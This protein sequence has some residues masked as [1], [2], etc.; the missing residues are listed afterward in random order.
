[1]SGSVLQVR[2]PRPSG[3]AGARAAIATS[4]RPARVEELGP[5]PAGSGRSAAFA[6]T[7]ALTI[8]LAFAGVALLISVVMLAVDPK[9]I[10]G[11]DTSQ[12]QDAETAVYLAAFVVILPLALIAGP[13]LSAAIAAGPNASALSSLTALL[14]ST[15]AAAIGLVRLSDLEWGAGMGALLGAAG[16]WWVAAAALLARA[17]QAR[18]WRPLLR[19]AGLAPKLWVV[20]GVL[21]L[22]TLLTVTHLD[23]LSPLPLVLGAAIIPAVVVLVERRSLPR[24]AHRWGVMAEGLIVAALVLATL[25]LVIASP[26]DPGSLL[27]AFRISVIKQ[28]HDFL[29]GPANQVL[30]GSAMLVDTA[31]QYGVGSILFLAGWFK[32]APIGYGTLGFLD[33]LLTALFFVAGYCLL[34]LVGASRLLAASGLAVAV[35]A[36]VINRSYPVGALPQEGPLRFGLPMAL[37]LATVVAARWPSRSRAAQA[38]AL[39]V[40]ALSSIWSAE[41]LGFT[42]ATYSAMVCFQACLLPPGERLVWLA[43]QAAMAA[44]A[45]VCAHLLFA[46]G[47]LAGSGRLPD[48]GQYFAYLDAYLFGAWGDFTYDF[49][50][51]SPGLVVGAGYLASATAVVLLVRQ[52]PNIVRRERVAIL[53]VTGTTAYGIVFFGYFVGRSSDHVVAYV[54]LPAIL[55]GTLW[56]SLILRSPHSLLRGGRPGVL[57]FALSVAV[58]LVA[59]AWSSIGSRFEQSALAHALPGG[60]SPGEALERLWHFPPTNAGV[61]EAER[62]L[63]RYMPGEHR[64]LV[65]VEHDLAT[66]ILVRSGRA[67]RLPIESPWIDIFVVRE[68]LPTLRDAVAE[69]QPGDRMLLDRG[70]LDVLAAIRAD[71]AFDAY[72]DTARTAP[73]S[74]PMAPL[75]RLALQQIDERV[76]LRTIH[77]DSGG[78]TVVQLAPRR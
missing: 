25:D 10:P 2:A 59:V 56:L 69:L 72:A 71:P 68:R 29:L 13:R 14:L 23:T 20:A 21:L 52:R 35:I 3:P 22:G 27:A 47:T 19:I 7:L 44:A 70:A 42:A 64:T 26:E 74:S 46:V 38:G 53:A 8:V 1:V 63:D 36:L 77:R 37:I 43:R 76:R 15:L 11:F 65:L 54:S 33:G 32:L 78:F 41:A 61:V 40:L 55:I 17:A 34:R 24:L 39:A 9:P 45:C 51:W 75:Q 73:R 66:E 67:N 50:P 5:K 28:H 62:L 57:A 16:M 49:P 60:D 30:G 18:A 12:R 31:T 58:L 6:P 48:W 4:D